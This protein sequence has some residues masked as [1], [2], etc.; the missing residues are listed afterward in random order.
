MQTARC[1]I[2][3]EKETSLI[4]RSDMKEALE[5]AC[6]NFTYAAAILEISRVHVMRLARKYKFGKLAREMRQA[7]G[8]SATGRPRTVSLAS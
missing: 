5:C 2:E 7:V 3:I 4:A 1:Q 8:S 6:G